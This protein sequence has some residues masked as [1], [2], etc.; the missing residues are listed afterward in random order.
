M[1]KYT[2]LYNFVQIKILCC[3]Q[4]FQQNAI[5]F[6]SS[7]KRHFMQSPPFGF[8]KDGMYRNITGTVFNTILIL[9]HLLPGLDV[10]VCPLLARMQ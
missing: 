6:S 7:A 1:Y 3:N 9:C 5:N 4:A 2:I 8:S 10:S